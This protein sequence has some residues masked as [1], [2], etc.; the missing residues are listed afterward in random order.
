MGGDDQP[1]LRRKQIRPRQHQA[2]GD[3]QRHQRGHAQPAPGMEIPLG[4]RAPMPAQAARFA[5]D[6]LPQRPGP[7][8]ADQQHAHHRAQAQRRLQAAAVTQRRQ[9]PGNQHRH[10]HERAAPGDQ[11]GRQRFA[12]VARH[13]QRPAAALPRPGQRQR[14]LRQPG[15]ERRQRAT[16]P[17]Q[18]GQGHA[19]ETGDRGQP[20]LLA[21]GLRHRRVRRCPAAAG[22]GYG[23]R[24]RR[25]CRA[26][27]RRLRGPACVRG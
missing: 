16:D 9:R 24:A 23:I 14:R 21:C 27:P 4:Q 8:Q 13:R 6:A 11:Q 20:A 22:T 2:A 26:P 15:A 18:R 3:R 1:R 5:L 7:P 19:Q 17:A 25:G 12:P 10:G